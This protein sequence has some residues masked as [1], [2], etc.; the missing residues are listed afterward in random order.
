MI[1]ALP[2]AILSVSMASA[3]RAQAP[4]LDVVS[5]KAS[6]FN[7]MDGEGHAVQTFGSS[8]NVVTMRN[9]GLHS[10]VQWAYNVEDFQVSGRGWSDS[11]RY[12]INAKAAGAVKV[13]ELSRMKQSE[14]DGEGLGGLPLRQTAVNNPNIQFARQTLPMPQGGGMGSQSVPTEN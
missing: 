4:A 6:Q 8:P 11:L 7:N 10:C 12:D 14:G 13:E 2:D 1:T 3:I 5:V 9:F